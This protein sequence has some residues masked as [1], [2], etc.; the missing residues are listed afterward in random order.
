MKKTIIILMLFALGI[1]LCPQ[2]VVFAEDTPGDE[3]P[4]LFDSAAVQTMVWDT[5]TIN[6]DEEPESEPEPSE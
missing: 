6:L 3:V 4:E 2:S 5:G 1:T